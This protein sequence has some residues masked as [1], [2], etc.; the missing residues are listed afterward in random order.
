MI[1]IVVCKFLIRDSICG[2]FLIERSFV[3][4]VV[5][6]NCVFNMQVFIFC[7]VVVRM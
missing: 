4:S 3:K 5:Y 6:N 1:I 2:L 7:V